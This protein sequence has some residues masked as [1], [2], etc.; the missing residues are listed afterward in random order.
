MQPWDIRQTSSSFTEPTIDTKHSVDIVLC[1][2]T[3]AMQC[4]PCPN[5]MQLCHCTLCHAT[6]MKTSTWTPYT[7]HYTVYHGHSCL[8]HTEVHTFTNANIHVILTFIIFVSVTPRIPVR[9]DWRIRNG[10]RDARLKTGT[11]YLIF[12]IFFLKPKLVPVGMAHTLYRN[13]NVIYK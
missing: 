1:T 8:M 4:L 2:H 6:C 13:Q 9:P 11:L 10:F 5:A 12:F 3:H 7:L